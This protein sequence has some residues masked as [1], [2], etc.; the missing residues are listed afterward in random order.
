MAYGDTQTVPDTDQGAADGAT[1]ENTYA[2]KTAQQNAWVADYPNEDRLYRDDK[3][4]AE[5]AG[6]TGVDKIDY[7]EALRNYESRSDVELF[8]NRR[9]REYATAFEDQDFARLAVQTAG[10]I[11][12]STLGSTTVV[13][14]DDFTD[15]LGTDGGPGADNVAGTAD[16]PADSPDGTDDSIQN[17]DGT[18]TTQNADGTTTTA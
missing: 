1:V 14:G 9:A 15:V 6:V 17:P 5:A 11:Q 16:D 2:P 10:P 12:S 4:R 13:L 8:A 7:A 3:E 18:T